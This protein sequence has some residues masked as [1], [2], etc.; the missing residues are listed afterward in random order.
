MLLY[1]IFSLYRVGVLAHAGVSPKP[2]EGSLC[3][4]VHHILYTTTMGAT[5]WVAGTTESR[6]LHSPNLYTPR[7]RSSTFMA[8]LDQNLY[9]GLG[10]T[11]NLELYLQGLNNVLYIH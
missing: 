3:S 11:S 7:K 5:W 6:L 8:G 10:D 4:E 2:A 9:S 1:I